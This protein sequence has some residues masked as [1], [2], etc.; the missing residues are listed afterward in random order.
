[1]K[2]LKLTARICSTYT[3]EISCARQRV[4][5][6]LK[7][8]LQILNADAARYS[9]GSLRAGAK[10]QSVGYIWQSTR[11]LSRGEKDSIP[12]C[13]L[14]QI[15]WWGIH[16]MAKK[17]LTKTERARSFGCV[18]CGAR[19][20]AIGWRPRKLGGIEFN[21]ALEITLCN[22]T[23]VAACQRPNML[24][25]TEFP[26]IAADRCRK[27]TA[28]RSKISQ[29]WRSVFHH[30]VSRRTR[31]LEISDNR[32][33]IARIAKRATI[34][35]FIY[36]LCSCSYCSGLTRQSSPAGN[37]S[38]NDTEWRRYSVKPASLRRNGTRELQ[39]GNDMH[40]YNIYIVIVLP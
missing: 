15:R 17:D 5:D 27:I 37:T 32:S 8:T 24:Y 1:V 10:A 13:R 23:R 9:G 25:R 30:F 31:L 11:I 3:R 38:G 6:W 29:Q 34:C 36:R 19:K 16:R 22:N 20:V 21:L 12:Y 35:E 26:P 18:R 39:S 14:P 28:M 4:A 7:R 33:G 40:H 2:L